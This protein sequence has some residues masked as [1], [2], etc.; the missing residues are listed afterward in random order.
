LTE[1]TARARKRQSA[2][3]TLF[4][5]KSVAVVGA[6][7][8]PDKVGRVVFDNLRR[9][10]K[11]AIYPVNPKAA[12]IAGRRAYPSVSAIGR[13]VDVLV[14]AIPAPY[15][16]STIEEGARSGAKAAVIISA[17]F[18]ETG[19]EGARL[20]KE[21][22][23][24]AE[25]HGIKLIGPNCLGVMDTS[26]GLNASFAGD[27]PRAGSV[28]FMSQSG[29]LCTAILDWAQGEDVGFSKFISLGNKADISEIDLLPFLAEDPATSVITMYIEGITDGRS[30]MEAAALA[31][32][33]KPVIA[34]K[35]GTTNAGARAVSSHTGTLAGSESAYEAAFRQ[36][37]II[38]ARSV[39]DLFDFALGFSSQPIPR[40]R[41]LAVVTNAGGPGIMAADEIERRGL[42]L[43]DFEHATV[44]RLREALPAEASFYN[45]VDVLGDALA[46]RY[47]IAFKSLLSDTNVDSVV[48]ILTPQAMTEIAETAAELVQVSKMTP[49]KPIFTAFMGKAEVDKGVEVLRSGSI[50]NFYFPERAVSIADAMVR[51]TEIRAKPERRIPRLPANKI[52]VEEILA[53]AGKKR[54][55]LDVEALQLIE[56]YG[57]R[58]PRS[59]LA[60]DRA[61]A[62][63][64]AAEIR[65]PVVLKVSSPDVLHKSDV[66]AVKVGV[67]NDFELRRDYREVLDNVARF[68]PQADIEGVVVQEM[69]RGGRET[70]IGMNRDPQ[71]GPLLIFGL[72]GIYVEVLKD[73]TCRLAPVTAEEA[74]EMVGEIRSRA[75]LEGVRGEPRADT[76]AIVDSILKLSQLVTDWPQIT[77]LDINPLMVMPTGGG[78]VAADA[79]ILLEA[80]S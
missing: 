34:L 60:R 61:Q 45:P 33:K 28:A 42:W 23:E 62:L 75:L 71:F 14:I 56:A 68:I 30:F 13:P 73:V 31:S 79:R 47:G 11:G 69:V 38:R 63:E 66:G 54:H 37:G 27:L 74:R 40:G 9:T 3:Q 19:I 80:E 10:F 51:Y 46:D 32:A 52:T 70:I 26:S 5:P 25:S 67:E 48:V 17:G 15:I 65:Y 64:F 55:L 8:E 24:T 72:G 76:E 50:P 29:A 41:S 16:K 4:E 22:A 18:K 59:R 58:V 39:A 1:A 35:S 6:A 20:E 57:I 43:A 49:D 12:E 36:S 21:L 2:L 77:E 7:R 44:D 53:G 78:T